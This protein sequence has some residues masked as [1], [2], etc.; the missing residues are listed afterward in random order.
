MCLCTLLH[1]FCVARVNR[2][3]LVRSVTT[4][5]I[6]ASSSRIWCDDNVNFNTRFYQRTQPTVE[7]NL[8]FV[9]CIYCKIVITANVLGAQQK[10]ICL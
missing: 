5:T 2:F 8:L 1:S 3:V 4:F 6:M 7:H 10:G 9:Q